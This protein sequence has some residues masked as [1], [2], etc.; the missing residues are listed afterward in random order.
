[1]HTGASRR[2]QGRRR[3]TS[4]RFRNTRNKL[5][6]PSLESILANLPS[7]ARASLCRASPEAT[8]A[9]GDM[10]PSNNALKLTARLRLSGRR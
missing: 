5:C 9:G 10:G 2:V 8:T 3:A 4:L 7:D 1:V 6:P